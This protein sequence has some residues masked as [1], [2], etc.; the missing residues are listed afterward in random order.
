MSVS[1]N[2]LFLYFRCSGSVNR[3]ASCSTPASVGV[4]AG[5]NAS[6]CPSAPSISL[7]STGSGQLDTTNTYVME[8]ILR[9]ATKMGPI[10]FF[11]SYQAG[12]TVATRDPVISLCDCSRSDGMTVRGC[13]LYEAL[14]VDSPSSNTNCT[15]YTYDPF[16][17]RQRLTLF[18][19]TICARKPHCYTVEPYTNDL[20]QVSWYLY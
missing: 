19:E 13:S 5:N 11:R 9:A 20:L 7:Y 17:R 10:R 4:L 12:F 16:N 14:V 1:S 2:V 6:R 15:A 18:N 3:I 8:Y